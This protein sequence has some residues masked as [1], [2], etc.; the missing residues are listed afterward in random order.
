MTSDP[1]ALE[2][3]AEQRGPRP[4]REQIDVAVGAV[5]FNVSNYPAPIAMLGKDVGPLREK[6]VDAV[7]AAFGEAE[8]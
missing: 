4:T 8:Q 6:V 1:T 7:M 3:A 2:G 5:L